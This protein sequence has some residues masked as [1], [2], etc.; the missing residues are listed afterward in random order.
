M[1][2]FNM[3]VQCSKCKTYFN[4]DQNLMSNKAKGFSVVYVKMSGQLNLT[5]KSIHD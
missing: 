4:V 2:L 3:I 1:G 5:K